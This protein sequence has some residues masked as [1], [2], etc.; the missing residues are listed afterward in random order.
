M[1]ECG[2]LQTRL[3]LAKN[4]HWGVGPAV[5]AHCVHGHAAERTGSEMADELSRARDLCAVGPIR[6]PWIQPT[7]RHATPVVSALVGM[8][9]A[10]GREDECFHRNRRE[11]PWRIDCFEHTCCVEGTLRDSDSRAHPHEGHTLDVSL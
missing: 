1:G 10:R 4:P 3:Y 6:S 9:T 2:S 11:C 8:E 5:N 7:S